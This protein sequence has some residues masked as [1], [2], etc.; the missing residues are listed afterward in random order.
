[1]GGN[2]AGSPEIAGTRDDPRPVTPDDGR[3]AAGLETEPAHADGTVEILRERLR[4]AQMENEDLKFDCARL[5][6]SAAEK[7]AD[8]LA[9]SRQ[10]QGLLG[11]IQTLRQVPWRR[12]MISVRHS[13]RRLPKLLGCTALLMADATVDLLPALCARADALLA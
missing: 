3:A 13:A 9:L 10:N 11:Q 5:R 2:R 4:R 7:Q 1:M 8:I 6:A 12:F